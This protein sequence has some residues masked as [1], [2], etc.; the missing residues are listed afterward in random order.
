LQ[1]FVEISSIVIKLLIFS[2]IGYSCLGAWSCKCMGRCR[3]FGG[4]QKWPIRIGTRKWQRKFYFIVFIQC[5]FVVFVFL[6]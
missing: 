4:S 2:H 1:I 5:Y 6:V 3:T